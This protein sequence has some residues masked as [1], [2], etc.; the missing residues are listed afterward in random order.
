MKLNIQPTQKEISLG[1][2]DVIVSKTDLSGRITYVNRAFMRIAN[3]SEEDVLG[4]QHNIVRH[5]DM[6]RGAFKLLWDTLQQEREFFGY[7][8]NITSDG[9]YYWVFANVT[10]D[11]D[12]S[13][14]HIG[15]FSVRR[16][17]VKSAVATMQTIYQEMLAVE[18]SSH[19][20][21]APAASIA[22]LQ[23]KLKS[24]G[25]SYDRFILALQEH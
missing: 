25:T 20:A 3:F 18:K 11:R 22:L 5:P 12:A 21:Q 7:V 1:D 8:K 4:Q 23:S 13:G 16:K 19:A 15:Y 24:M 14:K 6:P 9:D 17:P 2:D 10:P